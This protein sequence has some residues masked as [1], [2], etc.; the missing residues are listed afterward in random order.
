M[1][2]SSVARRAVFA[3]AFLPALSGCAGQRSS[4]PRVHP[5]HGRP[6]ALAEA[7]QVVLTVENSSWRPVRVFLVGAVGG[8]RTL[9]RV[10]RGERRAFRLPDAVLQGAFRLR[11]SWAPGEELVTEA[12]TFSPGTRAEWR[13]LDGPGGKPGWYTLDFH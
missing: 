11:V 3:L 8:H 12:L 2:Q 13:L 4:T 7:R 5:A 9:G 1:P 10:D 6:P